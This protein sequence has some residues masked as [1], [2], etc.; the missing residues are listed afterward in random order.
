MGERKGE[1]RDTPPVEAMSAEEATQHLFRDKGKEPTLT[2]VTRQRFM[3]LLEYQREKAIN[4]IIEKQQEYG[5]L[6]MQIKQAQMEIVKADQ[7]EKKVRMFDEN[8]FSVEFFVDENGNLYAG[9]N[10]KEQAGFKSRED[11]EKGGE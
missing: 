5:L 8:Q 3:V 9:A 10:P 4:F 1:V 11:L 2:K 6:E 7:M